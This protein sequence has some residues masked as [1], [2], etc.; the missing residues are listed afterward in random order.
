MIKCA[1]SQHRHIAVDILVACFN[2]ASVKVKIFFKAHCRAMWQ[3]HYRSSS[4]NVFV[5]ANFSG[6]HTSCTSQ[7]I[8]EEKM[9][10]NVLMEEDAFCSQAHFITTSLYY[11]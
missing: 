1:S 4:L 9:G 11:K 7:S 2:T 8:A 5:A 10:N 6:T 3:G